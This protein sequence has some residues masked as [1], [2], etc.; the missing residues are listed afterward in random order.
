[1]TEITNAA[2]SEKD[3][4]SM[5]ENT[6]S[7]QIIDAKGCGATLSPVQDPQHMAPPC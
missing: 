6:F 3:G 5:S 7:E 1:M 2:H 4:Y